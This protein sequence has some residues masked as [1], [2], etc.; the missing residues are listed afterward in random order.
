LDLKIEKLQI[1]NNVKL[2]AIQEIK[3]LVVVAN[4]SDEKERRKGP[5][6]GLLSI[7]VQMI[8][9]IEK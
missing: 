2:E 9:K 8:N 7:G 5:E 3:I 4:R 1:G 6:N